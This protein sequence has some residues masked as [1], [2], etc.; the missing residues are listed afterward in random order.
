MMKDLITI[1]FI[2][3]IL[4]S[5]SLFGGGGD[6]R[7]DIPGKI[8]FSAKDEAGTSQIFTMKANGSDVKQLTH[9][10]VSEGAYQ[11]SWSPDGQQILF[12]SFKSGSSIGPAL[13]VIDADG[14][15]PHLL[16]KVEGSSRALEGN[17]AR[18]S[19][20]G[21]KVAFDLCLNCQI[22]T[23]NDIYLFDTQSKQV[24]QLTQDSAS[25][26]NPAWSP[27]GQRIAFAS[28]RDYVDADTLR[29][30]KDLYLIDAAGSNLQR[31][32]GTGNVTAPRWSPNGKI[33]AFEWNI[34]GNEVFIYDL[35]GRQIQKIET[36]FQFAGNP[37]WNKDGNQLLIFGR[38]TEQSKPEARLINIESGSVKIIHKI[39]L[40]KIGR[41]YDWYND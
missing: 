12:S 17:H 38:V 24:T 2:I 34:Q 20:D 21:T 32:T 11:P 27:D 13:W 37:L 7:P 3:A 5:C 39:T 23:N 35:A 31:L 40:D 19:P 10:E 4:T 15:N 16:Y 25:D 8:V 28:D 29:F 1:L 9:F 6:S 22:R 30:R 41:N 33:I 36:G 14:S 26:T 18:W